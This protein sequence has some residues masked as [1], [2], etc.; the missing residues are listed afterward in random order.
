MEDFFQNFFKKLS[1]KSPGDA[2]GQIFRQINGPVSFLYSPG[3][4]QGLST[5]RKCLQM[6]TAHFTNFVQKTQGH[7]FSNKSDKMTQ[8]RA[9]S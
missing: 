6:K 8:K 4:F 9:F 1:K 7:N 2:P 5:G 3:N